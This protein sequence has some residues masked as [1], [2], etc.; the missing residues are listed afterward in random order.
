MTKIY[1][2]QEGAEA[3]HERYTAILSRWP[4]ENEQRRLAT[5]AGETFVVA[6]GPTEAPPVLLFHGAGTNS[7]M[8]MGDAAAW[9]EHFRLYAVDMIG[10]PGF[11]APARPLLHSDG[12]ALWLDDVLSALKLDKVSIVGASMGGWLALDYGTRRPERV[13]SLALLCPAGVGRQR[14]G[15]LAKILPLMALG[16]W[17]RQRAVRFVMGPMPDVDTARY[18][19][20]ADF[21]S[22]L[23]KHFMPEKIMLPIFDDA[24]LR[25]LTMPVMAI[26]GGK[27]VLL[28]SDDTRR[29]LEANVP[30]AEI[31]YFPDKGHGITGQTGPILDFLRR[32]ITA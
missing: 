15:Y 26:V 11:S 28:D 21:F 20:F 19:A 17:G 31:R 32:V 9:A 1:R 4:V 23:L 14:L 27:D 7:F 25:R 6:C 29:R 24:A 22:L 3:V 10:Q 18:A 2:S 16:E 12:Y 8:W 13:T 5:R 30:Q